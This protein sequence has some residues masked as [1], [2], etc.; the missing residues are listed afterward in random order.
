L[1]PI[2]DGRIKEA[3]RLA[4]EVAYSYVQPD[5]EQEKGFRMHSDLKPNERP[6]IFAAPSRAA[7]T[8]GEVLDSLLDQLAPTFQLPIDEY[9]MSPPPIDPDTPRDN[10]EAIKEFAKSKG[11]VT[12]YPTPL[13]VIFAMDRAIHLPD[14]VELLG[15]I[16]YQITQKQDGRLVCY[17]DSEGFRTRS[18]LIVLPSEGGGE[19]WPYDMHL[20]HSGTR[21]S[22]GRRTARE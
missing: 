18:L 17:V 12:P 8:P 20:R 19:E 3:N 16:H 4:L 1:H 7:S 6:V 21:S 13:V 11:S 2:P 10:L 9:S 14:A 5:H 22:Y 15:V